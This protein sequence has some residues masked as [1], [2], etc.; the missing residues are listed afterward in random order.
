MP[1]TT[2]GT[3]PVQTLTGKSLL[4]LLLGGA[5]LVSA[6]AFLLPAVAGPLQRATQRE[7]REVA[8]GPPA[9]LSAAE[10]DLVLGYAGALQPDDALVEVRAGVQAKR[11]NVEGVRLQ[12]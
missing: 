1:A 7:R 5:F 12:G 4:L 3:T 6:V 9:P 8:T 11:S 2:S 10:R